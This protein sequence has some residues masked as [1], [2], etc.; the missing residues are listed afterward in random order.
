M[1]REAALKEEKIHQP[2]WS[3]G[4]INVHNTSLF[5]KEKKNIDDKY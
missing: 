5:F 1:K 2:V 3:F 4:F